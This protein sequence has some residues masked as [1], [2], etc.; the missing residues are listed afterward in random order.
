MGFAVTGKAIEIETF[1][2]AACTSYD[3]TAAVNQ[4]TVQLVNRSID[5]KP[6]LL[7]EA[8]CSISLFVAHINQCERAI[9]RQK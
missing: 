1:I 5:P 4:S 7:D 9:D 2:N 8:K 3:A 6:Q